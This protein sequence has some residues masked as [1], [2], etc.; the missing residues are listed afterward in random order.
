[1]EPYMLAARFRTR[2]L[3]TF[4]ERAF[5]TVTPLQGGRFVL[6]PGDAA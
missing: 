4:D 6:L 2:R 1:M 5:R 3:L